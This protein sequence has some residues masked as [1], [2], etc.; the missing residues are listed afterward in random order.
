MRLCFIADARSPIAQNWIHHFIVQGHEVH[1]IS[2]YPCKPEALPG[3]K[4]L[5][6][7]P[8]AFSWFVKARDAKGTRATCQQASV[9]KR[10]FT[11]RMVSLI[12]AARHWLGPL[13]VCRVAS[14]VR[15]II[16][17]IN[18]DLVHA[19]RIPFEGMLAA[20]ALK[21]FETP[22]L[23]SVWGN[24]FTH[25]AARFPLIGWKTSRAVKRVDGLHLDCQRDLHLAQAWGFDA[26]RPTVVLPG[27]G[28]IQT[29][30]F[31]PGSA[32][33]A[34]AVRWAIPEGV[35]VVLNPRGFRGYVR[36]DTF[37]RSIPLVLAR[38]ADVL[39]LGLAMQDN[40]IADKW[41]KKLS[42]GHAVRLLPSVARNQMANL[43]RLADV[44][45]SPSEHDGTPN[46]L[47]EAMACGCFPVAGDIESVREWITDG[48][49]GL[50][51][52]PTDP[53]SLAQA[54]VRALSDAELRRR[55]MQYNLKLVAERAEYGKVMAQAEKF[56]CQVIHYFRK[57]RS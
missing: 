15:R 49:N 43:F 34:L 31:H 52:D 37:F 32:D 20:Q 4:S 11:G 22:L 2:S 24:D 14:K 5:R 50:L 23:I 16:E 56:Y 51:C 26:S 45:V 47:L 54:I 12:Y 27:N 1:I 33:A 42:V 46:T 25:F 29:E 6:V 48:V 57:A 36:N 41:V 44:T 19:M 13:D 21:G 3:A 17:E 9:L 7:V 53:E 10:L 38:R 28:G 40:P 35:P 39:F 55:A 18:P 30:L 8:V